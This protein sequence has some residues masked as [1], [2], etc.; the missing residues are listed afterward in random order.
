[1][2]NKEFTIEA[3]QETYRIGKISPVDLL[4][5]QMQTDLDNFEQTRI[6]FKF[7]LE[8]TEVKL[9]E[10]W[11]PVKTPNRDIYMPIGMEEDF[12]AMNEICL[13]F[14]NNELEK[15]FPKSSESEETTK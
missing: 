15:V 10:T 5:L 6:L 7:A 13:Y 11:K 14:M 12:K 8:H 1:M 3:R 4:A 2:E 9:G